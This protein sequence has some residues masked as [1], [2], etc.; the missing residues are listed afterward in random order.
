VSPWSALLEGGTSVTIAGTKLGS[1]VD[2]VNDVTIAG[3]T[4]QLTDTG[5]PSLSR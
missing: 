1:R 3:V 5:M 4:C 2:Q